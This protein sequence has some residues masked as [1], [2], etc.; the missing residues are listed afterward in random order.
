MIASSHTHFIGIVIRYYS[1]YKDSIEA[2]LSHNKYIE[3]AYSDDLKMV[4]VIEAFSEKELS[5][6]MTSITDMKGVISVSLAY[7]QIEETSTLNDI[8]SVN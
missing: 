2:S 4:A 5:E 6:Q 8:A 7:H 3:L 1:Q